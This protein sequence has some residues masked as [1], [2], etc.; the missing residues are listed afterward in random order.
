MAS[1]LA[2][3]GPLSL[4]RRRRSISAM[5]AAGTSWGQRLGAELRSISAAVTAGAIAR[6]P[7]VRLPLRQ[8]GRAGGR[9]HR[10]ALLDHPPH[11]QES[12]L[13][14]QT[15]ILVQVHPGDLPLSA[16]RLATD[17]LTGLPG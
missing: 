2:I 12:T 16:D 1:L 17:S 10:P 7:A 11:Q 13:G 8:S 5:R 4:W 3:W 6:E 14:R 9:A 15:G